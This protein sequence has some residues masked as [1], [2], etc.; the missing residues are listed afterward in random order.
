MDHLVEQQNHL[1]LGASGL[2]CF[3]RFASEAGAAR[4]AAATATA[5]MGSAHFKPHAGDLKIRARSPTLATFPAVYAI[6]VGG[7]LIPLQE[8]LQLSGVSYPCRLTLVQSWLFLPVWGAPFALRSL[9][10]LI[11]SNKGRQ[12]KFGFFLRKRT[13]LAMLAFLCTVAVCIVIALSHTLAPYSRGIGETGGGARGGPCFMMMEWKVLLPFCIL[14]TAIFG[15]LGF[16]LRNVNDLLNIS[17]ELRVNFVLYL[18][19]ASPFFVLQLYYRYHTDRHVPTSIQLLISAMVVLAMVNTM[20]V[21]IGGLEEFLKMMGYQGR[22]GDG[23]TVGASSH[24]GS[25]ASEVGSPRVLATVTSSDISRWKQHYNDVPS[26]MRNARMSAVFGALA[27]RFL[28]SE[29]YDFLVAVADYRAFVGL[30]TGPGLQHMLFL[31]ICKNFVMANS[32]QEINISQDQ[33]M[34]VLQYT[35]Y[36]K[37]SPLAESEKREIYRDAEREVSQMLQLNLLLTFH[38]STA[39]A[40]TFA[41]IFIIVNHHSHQS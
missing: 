31:D 4:A 39:F 32:E 8:L 19:F 33:R 23:S 25:V 21:S 20:W 40:E 3:Q 18:L 16:R 24:G 2:A 34:D 35:A 28:C 29:S 26:I 5:W 12:D 14:Q 17:N 37:Y 9:R 36:R 13:T 15:V 41:G 27:N 30:G 22:N 11:A 6:V 1:A 38:K 10:V 7:L